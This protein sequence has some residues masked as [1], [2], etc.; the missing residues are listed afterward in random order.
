MDKDLAAA[1]AESARAALVGWSPDDQDAVDRL[2]RA[3]GLA[4][5]TGIA[6]HDESSAVHTAQ[7]MAGIHDEDSA[8]HWQV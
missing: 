3:I 1:A 7:T 8:D 4:V 5:A 6:R 2:T